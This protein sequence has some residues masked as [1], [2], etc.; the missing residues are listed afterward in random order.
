M[1]DPCLGKWRDTVFGVE[2]GL[3]LLPRRRKIGGSFY[4]QRKENGRIVAA[5]ELGIEI[6]E[7]PRR[8]FVGHAA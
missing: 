1:H 8:S 2:S 6:V 4:R 3:Q 7:L 5:V